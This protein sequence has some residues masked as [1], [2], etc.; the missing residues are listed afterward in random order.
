[1]DHRRDAN[2]PRGPS[3]WLP[4]TSYNKPRPKVQLAVG[5][6]PHQADKQLINEMRLVGP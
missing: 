1:M 2:L 3:V 4:D 5:D 6:A